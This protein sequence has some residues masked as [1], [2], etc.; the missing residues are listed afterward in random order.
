M[1][2]VRKPVTYRAYQIGS[3]DYPEWVGELIAEGRVFPKK[4]TFCLMTPGITSEIKTGHYLV[5][6]SND[7]LLVMKEEKFQAQFLEER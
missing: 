1:K 2:Y 6:G 7:E 3:G 4:D 5:Y